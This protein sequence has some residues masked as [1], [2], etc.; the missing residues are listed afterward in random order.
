[1]EVKRFMLVL[2]FPLVWMAAC[3]GPDRQD[4]PDAGGDE[5]TGVQALLW[6]QQAAETEALYLQ[7]FNM[8]ADRAREYAATEERLPPAVILDIDETVLDNSP[9]NVDMLRKGYSY[10]E[11]KWAEW[12]EMREALPLPGAL[13]FTK[14]ADSLGIKVFYVSNR[15]EGLMEATLE[16]LQEFG[17]PNADAAH[18]LLK[19]T[20]SSKDARRA[21]IRENY[22]VIL[23]LGDNLG[24][25]DGVF[26]DRT[27]RF[28]KMQVQEQ[29][30]L[31][32]R[33]FIVFPNP[34]YGSWVKGAFPGGMPGE[35]EVLDQLR[36]YDQ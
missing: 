32:G 35:K 4:S 16:N 31:F 6:Y 21:I 34:I 14:L 30:D 15:A 3:T 22:E 19:S 28:G 1:M 11:E 20:T 2:L 10:S 27:E 24:D 18:V 36:G 12:C 5:L 29:R 17:F 8:A 25:F 23:L 9:F 13:E 33:K 7:G 26:D